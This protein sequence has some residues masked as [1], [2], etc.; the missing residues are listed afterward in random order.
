MRLKTVILPVPDMDAAVTFYRDTLGLSPAS[1]SEWW[2]EL[3][4]GAAH[5]ALHP[6]QPGLRVAIQLA[7]PDL[8]ATVAALRARGVSVEGPRVEEGMDQP[9]AT[10]TAPDGATVVLMEEGR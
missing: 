9:T 6:A 3:E 1:V 10:L 4:T 5:V 8:E 2:S 7:C